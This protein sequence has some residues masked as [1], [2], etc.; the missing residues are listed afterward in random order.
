MSLDDR[1]A[2]RVE[3]DGADHLKPDGVA[4]VTVPA[5]RHLWSEMDDAVHHFRRYSKNQLANT[6]DSRLTI[7]KISFY[8]LILYPVKVVFVA[9]TSLLRRSR[10]AKPKKSY[11]ELPP[12]V[13]NAVFKFVMYV[14]ARVL[15]YVSLSFGV[16]LILVLKK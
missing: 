8:N 6:I 3:R 12:L 4:F 2:F 5:H 9:I 14:E 1:I 7:E 13:V 16:S 15:R 10:P 11:N